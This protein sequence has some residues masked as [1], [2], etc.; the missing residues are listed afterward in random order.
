MDLGDKMTI[1]WHPTGPKITYLHKVLQIEDLNPSVKITW[2]MTRF[3]MLQVA[4]GFLRAA[5]SKQEKIRC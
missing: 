2:R 1:W 4:F 3:E 5:C